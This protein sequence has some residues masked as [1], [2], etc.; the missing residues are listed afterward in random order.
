[1]ICLSLIITTSSLSSSSSSSP[2]IVL[3][4]EM[5][6]INSNNNNNNNNNNS[7]KNINI[8]NKNDDQQQQQQQQPLQPSSDWVM[9]NDQYRQQQTTTTSTPTTHTTSKSIPIPTVNNNNHTN[10]FSTTPSSTSSITT[11]IQ[12]TFSSSSSPPNHTTVGFNTIQ[13]NLEHTNKNTSTNTSPILAS[14]RIPTTT[15]TSSSSSSSSNPIPIPSLRKNSGSSFKL[16]SFLM[17]IHHHIGS[18]SSSSPTPSPIDK[19]AA[20]Q[21][22][23][24]SV[25]TLEH[26]HPS[27]ASLN[28]T[29]TT[30]LSSSQEKRCNYCQSSRVV[31]NDHNNVITNNLNN[32][33]FSPSTT[34]A[35]QG[36]ANQGF[37]NN[38]IDNNNG[39][40]NLNGSS[41]ILSTSPTTS[42]VLSGQK[43][44]LIQR[45]LHHHPAIVELAMN[46][47]MLQQ[48][49]M[50]QHVVSVS[51]QPLNSLDVSQ[52]SLISAY[53]SSEHYSSV[54]Y[55]ILTQLD[56]VD[57]RPSQYQSHLNEIDNFLQQLEKFSQG[58]NIQ[59]FNRLG[60]NIKLIYDHLT[61]IKNDLID[62]QR[63]NI[64]SVQFKGYLTITNH[65]LNNL[66]KSTQQFTLKFLHSI[67][68]FMSV[69]AVLFND[70]LKKYAKITITK[71]KLT[72]LGCEWNITLQFE[73]NFMD[74]IKYCDPI[75]SITILVYHSSSQTP[76]YFHVKNK[77]IIISEEKQFI[78][79]V[80]HFCVEL[81]PLLQKVDGSLTS[82]LGGFYMT[83]LYHVFQ[84]K[85]ENFQ[86]LKL[87]D[88]V[89]YLKARNPNYLKEVIPN[90]IKH[91]YYD[92]LFFHLW[93]ERC[94]HFVSMKESIVPNEFLG[95]LISNKFSFLISFDEK[96]FIVYFTRGISQTIHTELFTTIQALI[97]FIQS[98]QFISII[99]YAKENDVQPIS[100]FNT[101][102]PLSVTTVEQQNSSL[103]TIQQS[104]R[105]SNHLKSTTTTNDKSITLCGP[106]IS[107]IRE[108][109]EK[110]NIETQ[111]ENA[112]YI[113]F[114]K[115]N[116]ID[117]NTILTT[118]TPVIPT[119]KSSPLTFASTFS[120]NSSSSASGG[121]SSLITSVDLSIIKEQDRKW[122]QYTY[123][124][125]DEEM[126]AM[127]EIEKELMKEYMGLEDQMD[128]IVE[129]RIK[130]D[131][132]HKE[133][134]EEEKK[135]YSEVNQF[136]QGY[137]S[138]IDE[139]L[140]MERQIA[141]TREDIESLSEIN[142]L[143]E[144]FQISF[145]KVDEHTI[146]KINDLH[147]GTLP[148][149]HK[150]EWDEIN[151]A[152]GLIVLLV[153]IIAKQL[154]YN[155]I[156]YKL[157]PMGNK[158]IIQSKFDKEAY[159][160]YG[161]DDVYFKTTFM[162]WG[163]T[164]HKFDVGLEALL[165]CVNELCSLAFTKY[166]LQFAFKI[167]R[168]KIG[169]KNGHQSIRVS[170]NTEVNWTKALKYMVTNIKCIIPHL[171]KELS[172]NTPTTSSSILSSSSSSVFSSSSSSTIL[173]SSSSS[174]NN[175]NN[176]NP[177]KE[178]E[179]VIL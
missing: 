21:Q 82:S 141:S 146:V 47:E 34:N 139:K 114:L 31:V 95:R 166:N 41:T 69:P 27:P 18:P 55:N 101:I 78:G 13:Q 64:S 109:L 142:L 148:P 161:G 70:T 138:M 61:L 88:Y 62:I 115:D 60:D 5:Y 130:L 4:F 77:P 150:V 157:I 42:A 167:D 57:Q 170:G 2:L 178:E 149:K 37:N 158:P 53:N 106:C 48:Y 28:T 39:F 76:Q 102:I 151:G 51:Q 9:V 169:G 23:L 127:E 133:I 63:N 85:Q 92:P 65:T 81:I 112:T 20:Y 50:Q 137:F 105:D 94:I 6:N 45:H 143:R 136:Y 40:G 87:I 113:Q 159:P 36:F 116:S 43:Q 11:F 10:I 75:K 30:S 89:Y 67:T 124:A 131:G 162:L 86:N 120:Q 44:Q 97:T 17:G 1:M 93:N 38:N 179:E 71:H 12:K 152:M 177:I 59:I 99:I 135:H 117:I 22:Q 132:I 74:V 122:A 80:S 90:F 153:H 91:L 134:R 79:S 174:I 171:S 8:K 16:D 164:E 156:K 163:R 83:Y 140:L 145:E 73:R 25:V 147:L 154:N 29:T 160:L 24:N 107:L 108:F 119:I 32:I 96:N 19:E 155:F 35:I 46:V 175:N 52:E 66:D 125:L 165:S 98:N 49:K 58:L 33:A 118:T 54:Y 100:Y 26:P 172:S 14:T 110:L 111:S 7:S 3:I 168:D 68:P 103:V 15:N 176:N 121:G 173:S 84:N 123:Q 72:P 129:M 126:A 128:D 56:L 104:P 144:L